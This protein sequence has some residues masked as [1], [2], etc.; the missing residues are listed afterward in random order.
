MLYHLWEHRGIDVLIGMKV[1]SGYLN[2]YVMKSQG[3]IEVAVNAWQLRINAKKCHV[4]G[5]KVMFLTP[6]R[7]KTKG[8]HLNF[9]LL[10]S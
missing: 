8:S 9:L 1:F 3:Q 10:S 6:K 2:R 4:F 7:E 5:F